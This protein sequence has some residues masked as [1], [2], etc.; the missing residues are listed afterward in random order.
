MSAV[1]KLF[2]SG[3]EKKKNGNNYL[4]IGEIGMPTQVSHNFSGKINPDGTIAGIPESWKQRLKLMITS[5]EAENP[6]KAEKAALLCKWI[7]TRVR[8]GQSE[9][10]MRV[11]SDSPNN[12]LISSETNSDA[13]FVSGSGDRVSQEDS[14]SETQ[15]EETE[16]GE[17]G[18]LLEPSQGP[19]DNRVVNNVSQSVCDNEVPTLRRKKKARGTKQGPRVT[20]N[21]S[22]EQILAQLQDACVIASPWG[23]YHRDIEVGA[24]AAG[25]VS[26]ATHKVTGEKVA[27]KDID[28]NKQTKKDLI[29]MEIKVMKELHHPNLVN[30]KEAYLVEMH[31]FVVMEFMEGGPLTDVVTETVM[32]ESLIAMVCMEVVK[33][34]HY[35]HTKSILH[36]DIK[37]DNILLGMDGKVKITDF[38]FCANI[39]ENEQRN[40]M[41]GTP[42]WM[43]PEVV[44]RKHYGKKVDIWSLGIMALEMKDGEPPYLKEA[45]L[46]ALWLIA[47][48]GKPKIEG[49]SQMSEEFQDFLDKCL[50]VDVEARWSAEQLLTH[51]FL[52]KSAD[53]HKIVPLIKAAKEQLEKN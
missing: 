24:G 39:Q 14:L 27:V 49:R 12:S 13:S 18:E 16:G 43:A 38:G 47:Q 50:E 6:E 21:L 23:D 31:L 28:L 9:E 37:S 36:R 5:E 32:K 41:V 15:E 26:L 19:V 2:R 25:V 48:E 20:R 46:R 3:K 51:P 34:I 40:T 42:Y 1:L 52:L 11:N 22:E 4:D 45:P 29:L 53:N 7:D 33:G 30:F 35:L 17:P 44:N 8:D 10:F